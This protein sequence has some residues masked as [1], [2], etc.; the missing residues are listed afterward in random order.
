MKK[1]MLITLCS[2][3]I[4]L[5][6]QNEPVTI[7]EEKKA[8]VPAFKVFYSQKLVN[9]KTVEVLRKGVLEFNVSHSFGDIAGDF[10]GIKNFFGL[11]VSTDVRIG[12]QLGLSD[13]LNIIAAR[14]K[15]LFPDASKLWELGFK[16][17]FLQ[18]SDN[19]PSHP[20]SLTVYAN[21]VI[22][23]NQRDVL[24]GAENSYVDFGDRMSQV[25][26]MMIAK[27]FGKVSL[28]LNPLFLHT[29]L[30]LPSDD[31]GIFALGGA[32]RLP[33]SKK[34]VIVADYFHPFRSQSSK[35]SFAAASP[36]IEFHDPLGIGVE[37]LTEG[38]TFH[39]NFTNATEI[40][41]NRF[42]RRTTTSWGDGAFR[43][44]FTISRNFI[45]FKDKKSK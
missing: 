12:F 9:T 38:H 36:T 4:Q 33:L 13:R 26:Q 34:I 31:K 28:Q 40:L 43:W 5:F 21:N 39:L 22:S 42:I 35:D 18:Q 41:E 29:S 30:V 11:D 23:T 25:I 6:A 8:E 1:L 16:Y 7:I 17:Q 44:A 27:K 45:L 14:A 20:I 2:I 32:I 3:T 10:G 24:P 19:D 37:I 15:G